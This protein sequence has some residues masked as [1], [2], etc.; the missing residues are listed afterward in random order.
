[1][2]SAASPAAVPDVVPPAAAA[3]AAAAVPLSVMPQT[4]PHNAAGAP[5]TP[6][7][8]ILGNDAVIAARPAT[9]VQLAH[10]CQ[11]VGYD[12]AVPASWGDELVAAESVRQVRAR[13]DGAAILCA[14]PHVEARLLAP[15]P[16]LAPLLV[17]VV[18][19]PVAVARY[20]RRLYGGHPVHLTY[21][22]ACPSASADAASASPSIDSAVLPADFLRTLAE[23]GVR[24]ADQP[25]VYDSV[26]PPDR[27]RFCSLPG[28]A[29]SPSCLWDPEHGV[30][31]T[32]VEIAGDDYRA[33][34][35]QHLLAHRRSVVDLAPRLGCACSGAMTAAAHA[36]SRSAV[37][38]TEPPRAN[39]PVVEPPPGLELSR[40]IVPRPPSALTPPS[41]MRAISPTADAAPPP[42]ATTTGPRSSPSP[43][44][45]PPADAP[46][47]PP[48]P[49][50]RST[51]PEGS[52]SVTAVPPNRSKKLTPSGIFRAYTGQVPTTRGAE[53]KPLPRAYGAHR[54][55]AAPPPP[56][57]PAAAPANANAARDTARAPSPV[58][59]RTEQ[60]PDAEDDTTAAPPPLA[61]A[62][63]SLGAASAVTDT[64]TSAIA[65]TVSPPSS[66]RPPHAP[67]PTPPPT[68]PP[69]PQQPT[70]PQPPRRR[71]AFAFLTRDEGDAAAT[72]AAPPPAAG[73]A[74]ATA[75]RGERDGAIP[76]S[77][78][79]GSSSSSSS[80]V[81]AETTPASAPTTAPP[82]TVLPVL[83]A[84][85]LPAVPP[86]APID[87]RY[88]PTP[89]P[90]PRRRRVL[91]IAAGTVALALAAAAAA[92]TLRGGHWRGGGNGGGES[93]TP[94]GVVPAAA[95]TVAPIAPPVADSATRDSAAPSD[96]VAAGGGP[97]TTDSAA[98]AL[99]RDSIAAADSAAAAHA[100]KLA[101]DSAT[102]RAVDSAAAAVQ[103]ERRGLARL[104]EGARA[105]PR[106]AT[107]TGTAHGARS[108]PPPAAPAA[109]SPAPS[110]PTSA[111]ATA[112]ERDS[113]EREI[114]RRRARIDSIARRLDSLRAIKPA[115]PPRP[116]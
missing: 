66:E 33:E 23:H 83:A 27:R 42:A 47:P 79:V 86:K 97:A 112:A 75:G 36:N 54:K 62:G 74:A 58:A 88:G 104:L 46:L 25:T 63:D 105:K 81:D 12:A 92:L 102:R 57:P 94:P 70:V 82:P 41:S 91:P 107:T 3:A 89:I 72:T 11:R 19:P 40:V 115:T 51:P 22:G 109:T 114:A 52:A 10:A 37:A 55:T 71:S 108:A 8:V 103:R 96:S 26:I 28:G 61:S 21:V 60:S 113:I 45:A 76:S 34:L 48:P 111:A 98:G 85:R 68:S 38:A 100:A 65:E 53:G 4:V 14:C 13:G 77:P 67:T 18:A 39:G 78:T 110:T 16:D 30:T 59:P 43:S 9:A 101:A 50:G 116:R 32:L 56:P 2:K 15:G 106:P 6:S 24:V 73:E 87:V 69:T 20:L 95:A 7:V 29:P 99:A 1:M 17:G 90:R 93:S 44:S 31:H 5:P 35:A 84:R 64:V 80:G 49:T